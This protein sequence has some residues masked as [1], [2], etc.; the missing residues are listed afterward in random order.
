MYRVQHRLQ[1][2]AGLGAEARSYPLG[3]ESLRSVQTRKCS[4]VTLGSSRIDK[5]FIRGERPRRSEVQ[6]LL[7]RWAVRRQKENGK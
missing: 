5:L 2:Q 1:S 7:H 4:S 6:T 3:K